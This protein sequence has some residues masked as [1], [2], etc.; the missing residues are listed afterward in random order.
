M[1]GHDWAPPQATFHSYELFAREV[2]PYFRHQL[3]APR[4]SHDW[5][6]GIRDQLFGRAGQA[7][8]NAITEHTAEQQTKP[9]PGA[10]L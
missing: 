5:A 7:I 8:V 9:T 1:L 3:T 10:D 2:M 4:A 6:R